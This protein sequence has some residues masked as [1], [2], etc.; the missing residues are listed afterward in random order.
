MQIS[1]SQYRRQFLASEE[2]EEIKAELLAME[3]NP[4]YNT[5]PSYTSKTIAKNISFSDKHFDYICMNPRV[6]PYE[7]IAN[8]RLMTKIR[9]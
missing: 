4:L 9:G 8:L 1:A 7:Y 6:K 2:A 5:Q 3:Q